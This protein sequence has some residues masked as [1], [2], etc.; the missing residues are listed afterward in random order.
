MPYFVFL[1]ASAIGAGSLVLDGSRHNWRRGAFVGLAAS[2]SAV[3]YWLTAVP[4]FS[5]SGSALTG[6]IAT[7]LVA[8]LLPGVAGAAVAHTWRSGAG[9]IV[10]LL[11]L[12]ALWIPIAYVGLFSMCQLDPRC[13]L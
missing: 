11:V 10:G 8:I 1:V 6:G 13:D 9:L 2:V 7:L 5:G 4:H 12:L 3:A